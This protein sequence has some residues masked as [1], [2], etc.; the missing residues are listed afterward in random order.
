MWGNLVISGRVLAALAAGLFAILPATPESADIRAAGVQMARLEPGP[1]ARPPAR[2]AAPLSDRDAALYGQIFALQE[3]GDWTGAD[4]LIAKV[5]DPI[6][7]GHVQFQRY[8][9][10]TAYRS[11]YRELSDWLERY[12]D[13]PD[14]D[15]IYSLAW[16]RRPAGAKPL[17]QPVRG[18]LGGAGQEL[19]EMAR[20][21]YRSPRARAG[22][23]EEAVRA[24]QREIA[25]LVA[26]GEPSAALA[27]IDRAEIRA[28]IDDVEADL[29][30]WTVARGYFAQRRDQEAHKLAAKAAGRSGNVVPEIHWIA[31]IS[32]WRLER[33]ENA[34][35]HFAALAE[36]RKAH[37]AE[38]SRAAF[39]AA[40][41]H[42]VTGRPELVGRFLGLAAAHS[43]HFYGLLARAVL[44]EPVAYNWDEIGLEHRD[45]RTLMREPGARR[46]MALGQIGMTGL[47]EAEIRKLAARARPDLIGGLIALAQ[48]L[49]LPATQMRLAQRLGGVRNDYHH[50]ALYPVPRW[51]PGTGLRLDR[52][53]ILA[54][55]RAESAFDPNAESHVG[56]Q[57]LMQV[58]PATARMMARVAALEAPR[59]DALREPEVS[60]AFGQAYLEHLLQYRW[61]GDNLI[62]VAAGYNAGPGRVLEWQRALGTDN[63]PLLFLESI[64]M[65]EPR[66]YV[67]KVLTNLWTYRARL[68]QPQPSLEALAR[69]RWPTY[70]ALDTE[71][72][73]YAWN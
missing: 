12:A 14:A 35:A 57:G 5:R 49:H 43:R 4:A 9:H 24:W 11:S 60:M 27:E 33:I 62:Y 44:G 70:Q 50:G 68:G 59:G 13:H 51:Q 56:A 52:A 23:E 29:A 38:R 32:A 64:P 18:Y 34:A 17:A 15:R 67:K 6:L 16:K 2:L 37:P 39:W 26:K 31:G 63:D 54:I 48:S 40:R 30:L 20:V 41:A 8:M 46:A 69:N 73:L 72:V 71:P 10:P 53:L 25:Q 61:I 3:T 19:Q 22:H 65:T 58:M 66:V 7:M 28:L 47:A 55:A 21:S 42:M 36:A 45:L 1:A